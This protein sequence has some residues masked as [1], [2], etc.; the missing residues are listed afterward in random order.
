MIVIARSSCDETIQFFL[1]WIASRSLSS[2]RRSRT[3]WLA[4]TERGFASFLPPQLPHQRQRRVAE[5]FLHRSRIE[6]VDA[7]EILGM[8]AAGHEQAIDSK[9]M[10]AGQIGAYRIADREHAGK[11]RPGVAALGRQLHGAFVDRPVR[12][13]VEDHV[14]AQFAI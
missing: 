12:L 5:Q 10:G 8:N 1:F 6:L 11:R 9:T 14:A 2:G 7:L 4:M 3:R 13:A